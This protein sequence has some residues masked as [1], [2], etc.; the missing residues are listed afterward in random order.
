[1]VNISIMIDINFIWKY[2]DI[3]TNEV[4]KLRELYIK[5]L[6]NN[7]YAFQS[8]DLGIKTFLGMEVRDFILI[9]TDPFRTG[10][11][12]VDHTPIEHHYQLALQI[13]LF[14]C[15]NSVTTFYSSDYTPSIFYT[16]NGQPYKLY[17]NE[18]CLKISEFRLTGPLIFRIDIPHQVKNESA[19]TRK[20][21][22]V[23]FKKD[24]WHLISH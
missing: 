23:R 6:P 22:S 7:N 9:Q 2:V 16:K 24:P 8:L 18:K 10:T 13:P 12:H 14:D 21:I 11:I 3:D 15:D 5:A 20:A 1:M 19:K 17:D 4:E